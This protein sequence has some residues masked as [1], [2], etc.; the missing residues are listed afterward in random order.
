M[1][2]ITE[3]SQLEQMK[4]QGALFILFGGKQ[5]TVCQSLRPRLDSI[6]AQQFPDMRCV[7][8]DCNKS[9]DICAQH[10]VFSLPV[11]KAYIEGMQIAEELGA[12]AIKQLIQTIERPY[13][14]WKDSI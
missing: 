6:L 11:V 4:S 7:Y 14:M 9:P 5:C 13:K 3:S 2:N 10:S 8:I 12:F 1:Q